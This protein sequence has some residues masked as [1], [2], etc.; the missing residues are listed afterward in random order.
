MNIIT[1][2]KMNVS[3]LLILISLFTIATLTNAQVNTADIG[4]PCDATI[5][6]R[7]EFMRCV[8]VGTKELKLT[9]GIDKKAYKRLRKQYKKRAAKCEFGKDETSEDGDITTLDSGDGDSGDGEKKDCTTVTK[10]NQCNKV[11]GGICLWVDGNCIDNLNFIK[12]GGGTSINGGGQGGNGGGQGGNGG[13]GGGNMNAGGGSNNPMDTGNGKP[14]SMNAGGG[15]SKPNMNNGGGN[16]NNNNPNGQS[17]GKPNT[18]SMN[19]G[20]ESNIKPNGQGGNGGGGGGNMN[21]GGGGGKTKPKPPW[22][23]HGDSDDGED[24]ETTEDS[25]DTESSV[26]GVS[27]GADGDGGQQKDCSLIIKSNQC[28]NKWG[29]GVCSWIS[30]TCVGN[31][32]AVSKQSSL[33]EA[34]GT[35]PQPF[36]SSIKVKGKFS[37]LIFYAAAML[38]YQA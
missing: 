12:G 8:N 23:G 25:E 36:N 2:E 26:D 24:T 35:I 17:G 7:G 1:K 21:A 31:T 28:T 9:S 37:S 15:G 19:V 10:V 4:C 11:G 22:A 14:S 30:G 34:D 20:G 16:G 38:F 3:T 18:V 29:G 27:S 5:V 13:G 33:Q 6:D 32:V